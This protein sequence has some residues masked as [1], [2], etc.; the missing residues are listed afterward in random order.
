MAEADAAV[1]SVDQVGHGLPY[2]RENLH[3]GGSGSSVVW[4]GDV[5]ADTTHL[6]YS[7]RITPQ[8]GPLAEGAA[9]LESKGW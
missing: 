4:V 3:D 6:E 5:G 7:G 2:L 9:T 8:G 1:Q